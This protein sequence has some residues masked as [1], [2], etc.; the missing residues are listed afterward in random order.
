MKV[1]RVPFKATGYFSTLIE[2][3]LDQKESLRPFYHRYPIIENF[4]AQLEEKSRSFPQAHRTI[5]ADALATQYTGSKISEAT[6]RNIGALREANTFTVVTGHQ[7]NLFTGPLYFLYKIISVINLCEQLAESYP[8]HHF[9]PVFWMASEDHDF[10]E[11]DHFNFKG[12]KLQ[13]DRSSG[14]A[15][16]RMNTKGLDTVLEVFAAQ[17]GNSKNANTL[18]EW[19]KN[20]YLEHADLASA[21]RFLANSL[22][23]TYGLVIVDG[24]DVELKRLLIPYVKK[25]V[26]EGLPFEEITKS[27]AKLTSL[28]GNY[29]IQVNPR[30][31]NYFY[32]REGMRERLVAEGEGYRVN[33]TDTYFSRQALEDEMVAHPERFSPNVVA[34]PLYQ[35]TVLPNLCYVGGGGEL[36]YWLEL[37]AYFEAMQVPFPMLLL[38]NSALVMSEK[39]YRKLERLNIKVSDLF[40]KQNDL[41]NQKIQQISK[42]DLDFTSLKQTLEDQ[43]HYMYK[44]TEHTDAS[45]LGAVKAQ[46]AKQK[47]GLQNLEKRLLKAQKR[48]LKDHVTRLTDLQNQLFPN[49]SLQERHGNFSELY[50]AYGE[51][52]IPKLKAALDP[53]AEEFLIL[54]DQ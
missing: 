4:K 11:I 23:G 48:K 21:T 10:D 44:L 41:V 31:I 9:V 29:K 26:F 36:A 30:A 5:L 46:E 22:F 20:A 51:R 42:I 3:Y 6:Q 54:R 39:Q 50:L 25:D 19:F 8:D 53:L 1:D 40:K 28:S 13:W 49:Q 35:E 47:K 45:F 52:L 15:V 37:K 2:D 12:E 18:K 43:F 33:D 27:I 16:G 38:R 17:L 34:R 14:G 7:L 24:D 32:L